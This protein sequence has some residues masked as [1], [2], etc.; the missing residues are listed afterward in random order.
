V[1][2][3]GKPF[4]KVGVIGAG[5]L[6]R[7]MQIPANNLGIHLTVLAN[8]EAESAAQTGDYLIGNHLDPSA[9]DSLIKN[10]DVVTFEHEL[11]PTALLN[12]ALAAGAKFY[13]YP[14][15]FLYSQNKIEM[16]KLMEKLNAPSPKYEVW[17]GGAEPQLKFPLIAKLPTGGYDGRGVFKVNSFSELSELSKKTNSKLLLE[18]LIAFDYEAA[19][20]VARSPHNQVATWAPTKTIQENGIC[21]MTITPVPGISEQLA[22]SLQEI[23]ME[24]AAEIDLIGVMAV[25][26]FVKG[27]QYF[28]NE[29]ALRPH[30]SGHWSIEGANTSQF[31]QHLR[32]ILDLP[33]GSTELTATYTVMGNVLGGEK[34]DLYRP[35]LHLMARNPKLKFHQY[36]KEVKPGRKV[37]HVTLTGEDLSELI[38]E[39]EHAV[40]YLNGSIDE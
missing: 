4:P 34:T 30:N 19:I 40:A 9:I 38:K 6:A 25:E 14:K 36:G 1:N 22:R 26:V 37:G 32:A 10:C 28:I 20:M 8:N 13:P 3:G 2:Q 33:L 7:M 39:I 15:S 35:Y 27:D 16:R 11:T 5:Q 24:I 17:E 23:A 29:L 31:E 21:T 12:N 18:E